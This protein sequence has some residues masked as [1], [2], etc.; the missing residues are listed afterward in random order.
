MAINIPSDIE[1]RAREAAA[2]QGI[3][4]DTFVADVLE[5]GLRSVEGPARNLKETTIG[6]TSPTHSLVDFLGD[7]I[8]AVEGNGE[9]ARNAGEQFT[10][11]LVQKHKEGHL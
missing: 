7:L 4:A 6:E 10:D 5:K 2:R 9:R 8:G 11:S 1:K 3:D